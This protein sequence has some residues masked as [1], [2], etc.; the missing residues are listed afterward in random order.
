MNKVELQ[1][2]VGG[3]LQEKFEHAFEKV[4]ENLQDPNTS[5]KVKR[6]ITIKLD[7]VQNEKRD[8]VLVSVDVSEKLAPQAGMKTSFSIGKDLQTGEIYAE[9]Y[10]KQ[11][12][13]QMNLFDIMD[14]ET[15]EVIEQNQNIDSNKVVDLRK[16][17]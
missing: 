3:Q 12:K 9:E 5:F 17:F 14:P 8:D 15:G 6:G 10:G 16:A 11:I 2:L 1:N 4:L 13:G 7:F